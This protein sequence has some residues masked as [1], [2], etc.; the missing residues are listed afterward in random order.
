MRLEVATISGSLTVQHVDCNAIAKNNALRRAF[1][2]K[3]K[4]IIAS[5]GGTLA[6][7][8][9]ITLS[10]DA[11]NVSYTIVT[12]SS[13]WVAVMTALTSAIAGDLAS[14]LEQALK[15]IP[16]ITD[17][18]SGSLTAT[19]FSTPQV[20]KVEQDDKHGEK[21]PSKQDRTCT[22]KREL[23]DSPPEAT[24]AARL[25]L[26]IDQCLRF[27]QDK[28][29]WAPS[30]PC[31]FVNQFVKPLAAPTREDMRACYHRL[32]RNQQRKFRIFI[33]SGEA[34]RIW[35]HRKKSDF[36]QKLLHPERMP[37]Q[38]PQRTGPSERMLVTPSCWKQWPWM[39]D[40]PVRWWIGR[41]WELTADGPK[42]ITTSCCAP[43]LRFSQ[44]RELPRAHARPA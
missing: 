39:R 29:T 15:A 12:P 18:V 2:S 17:I 16:G 25:P 14:E 40:L 4:T 42:R 8:V 19:N 31:C 23:E 22:V 9:D 7:D 37:R 34:E 10:S 1:I 32:D 33:E 6:T 44:G 41:G 35:S 13:S 11:G 38:I 21:E 36:W 43:V 26:W 3:C 27:Q 5:K 28:R 20:I 30:R 24:F